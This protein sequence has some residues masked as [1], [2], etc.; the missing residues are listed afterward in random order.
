M[1]NC[2]LLT[3]KSKTEDAY[4]D[5][6]GDKNL[7]DFS[8]YPLNS[9]FFDPVDSKVIAKMKYEFKGKNINDVQ[10]CTD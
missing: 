2:C 1:L 9:K 10:R 7:F 8:N 3:Q 6:Y 5:F 4:E